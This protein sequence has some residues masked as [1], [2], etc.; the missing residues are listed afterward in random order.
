M[1]SLFS[2]F[3]SRRSPVFYRERFVSMLS[4]IHPDWLPIGI[5]GVVLFE[6]L[7]AGSGAG[8]GVEASLLGMAAGVP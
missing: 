7:V 8:L 6:A 1:E 5:Y 3:E 2:G 4:R